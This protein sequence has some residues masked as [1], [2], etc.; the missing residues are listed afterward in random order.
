[1]S[2]TNK[3]LVGLVVLAALSWLVGPDLFPF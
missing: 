2:N 3:L 1:M